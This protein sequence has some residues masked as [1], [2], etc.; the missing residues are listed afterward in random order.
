MNLLAHAGAGIINTWGLAYVGGVIGLFSVS[1]LYVKGKVTE[2]STVPGQTPKR[3]G[4]AALGPGVIFVGGVCGVSLGLGIGSFLERQFFDDVQVSEVVSELCDSTRDP[5][6]ADA[7]L[8]DEV[9]HVIGD[10]DASAAQSVHR[11]LHD[12]GLPAA[13]RDLLVDRLV[14]ELTSADD[15]HVASCDELSRAGLDAES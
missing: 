8:H 14:S 11:D 12:E 2:R 13:E 7:T 3:S 6:V 15:N 4:L 5:L 1:L 10:L 9:E